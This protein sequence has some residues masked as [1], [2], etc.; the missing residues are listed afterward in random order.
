MNKGRF[1]N[2]IQ[3]FEKLTILIQSICCNL[4]KIMVYYIQRSL[5]IG[6]KLCK[7]A[8]LTYYRI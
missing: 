6:R 5:P 1:C 4:P 7:I 8:I 2:W 3:N